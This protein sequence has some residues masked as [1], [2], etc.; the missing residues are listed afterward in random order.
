MCQ[1]MIFLNNFIGISSLT[2]TNTQSAPFLWHM[3]L[4]AEHIIFLC[5]GSNCPAKTSYLVQMTVNGTRLIA[6]WFLSDYA[7][8]WFQYSDASF[9]YCPNWSTYKFCSSCKPLF[10]CSL[11]AFIQNINESI[12]FPGFDRSM[13]MHSEAISGMFLPVRGAYSILE[14]ILPP[15]SS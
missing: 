8:T 14:R 4:I 13:Q 15:P 9:L 5:N 3:Y 10:E 2:D 7:G 12:T 6:I 11:A 1:F